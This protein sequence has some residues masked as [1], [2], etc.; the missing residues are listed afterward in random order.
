[1]CCWAVGGRLEGLS[2]WPHRVP[3]GNSV[4]SETERGSGLDGA[5]S[6]H[7]SKVTAQGLEESCS[8]AFPGSPPP[9][10]GQRLQIQ[11][12]Q[13]EGPGSAAGLGLYGGDSS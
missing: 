12:G 9:M 1:M 5:R 11:A 6:C 10:E 4:P 7:I 3:S 2:D 8:F 13:V